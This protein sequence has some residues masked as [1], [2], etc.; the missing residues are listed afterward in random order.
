MPPGLS[1]GA[2]E[3]LRDLR[4]H[5]PVTRALVGDR[6]GWSRGTVNARMD[7]LLDAGWLRETGVVEGARGRPAALFTVDPGVGELL[8]AD[9]GATGAQLARCDLSGRLL[10]RAA[11]ALDIADG[12]DAVLGLVTDRLRD[13]PAGRP[14]VGVAVGLPGPVHYATGRVVSPPIMTGWD[15]FAV[16]G[17]LDRA[18]EGVPAHVENDANAMAWGERCLGSG[19][20]DL[21][22]VKTGTGVGVGIVAN[23][24]VVRGAQGAAGDLGHTYVDPHDGHPSPLCRCGKTGCLEAYAGGWAIARDLAGD[25]VAAT[26]AADVVDLL[27]AGNPLAIRRVRDAGRVLGMGLAQAVNLLNPSEIVVGGPLSTAGEHLLAGVRE[28]VAARS[29]PL[30]TQNLHIRVSAHPDDV[31]PCGLA[32]ALASR[33]FEPDL[34]GGVLDRLAAGVT[35]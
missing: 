7:E 5:P 9:I 3:L 6:T 34:L 1:D 20:D 25:G 12:P 29:L 10:A 19:P 27:R 30:A 8:V 4:T 17:W 13:L 26:T 16:P 33:L 22:F 2:R 11:V 21:L 31:G 15:G 32:H 14:L 24:Q 28:H 23:G 18:F 35:V